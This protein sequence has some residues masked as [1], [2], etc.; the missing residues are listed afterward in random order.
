ML[1]AAKYSD[2]LFGALCSPW[3]LLSSAPDEAAPHQEPT[4]CEL[5]ERQQV[6]FRCPSDTPASLRRIPRPEGASPTTRLLSEEFSSMGGSGSRGR[7][8]IKVAVYLR[9]CCRAAA[10]PSS[11]CVPRS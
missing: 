8:R 7:P 4:D 1:S 5:K 11:A 10:I 2:E 9:I 6:P 3:R